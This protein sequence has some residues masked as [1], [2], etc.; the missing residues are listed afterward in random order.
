VELTCE[1]IFRL[2]RPA[3]AYYSQYST[4]ILL[5]NICEVPPA[6]QVPFPSFARWGA[7]TRS[8]SSVRKLVIRALAHLSCACS[9]FST[10]SPRLCCPQVPHEMI[11]IEDS[12]TPPLSREW[13]ALLVGRWA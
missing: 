5:E 1:Q 2:G 11:P 8:S 7:S 13:S 3:V 12:G 6:L 9:P 4:P 10:P